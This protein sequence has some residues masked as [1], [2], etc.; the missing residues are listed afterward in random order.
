MIFLT[1]KKG[2]QNAVDTASGGFEPPTLSD[3]RRISSR[4]RAGTSVVLY[5]GAILP[6]RRAQCARC[7]ELGEVHLKYE[8]FTLNDNHFTVCNGEHLNCKL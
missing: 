4:H 2:V 5:I 7:S 3:L 8:E 1:K 6:S